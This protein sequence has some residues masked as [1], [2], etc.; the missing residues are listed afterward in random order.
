M[1]TVSRP[2]L[3]EWLQFPDQFFLRMCNHHKCCSDR[4]WVPSVQISGETGDTERERERERERGLSIEDLTVFFFFFCLSVLSLSSSFCIGGTSSC[5]GRRLGELP[6]IS[7]D[8]R[9]RRFIAILQKSFFLCRREQ[10]AVVSPRSSLPLERI[11]GSCEMRGRNCNSSSS[12]SGIV[13]A[14]RLLPGAA[15]AAATWSHTRDGRKRNKSENGGG[16]RTKRAWE[17][18]HGRSHI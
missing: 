15:A 17:Q 14:T 3:L 11:S 13:A 12:S 5:S 1:A 18:H 6:Q 10:Q 4:K 2:I 9:R 7:N 8:K 16:A